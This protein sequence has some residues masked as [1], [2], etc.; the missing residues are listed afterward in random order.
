MI[1]SGLGARPRDQGMVEAELVVGGVGL[2]F[3]PQ[4]QAAAMALDER[5]A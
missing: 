3:E 2:A 5:L 1:K 4:P